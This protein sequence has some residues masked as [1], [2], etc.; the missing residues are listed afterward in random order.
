MNLSIKQ[1]QSH[2]RREQ[3][4]GCQKGGGKEWDGLGF[5]GQQ[6]QIIAFRMDKQ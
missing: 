3:T 2:K 5:G 6:M 1:E 4:C